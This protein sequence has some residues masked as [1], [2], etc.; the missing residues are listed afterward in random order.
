V[1]LIRYEP[2]RVATVVASVG[3][4]AF[5]VG[6]GWPLDGPS[7]TA[8]AF[9]S[10]HPARIDDYSDLPGT[11][12]AQTRKAGIT[13]TVAV[14]ITVDGHA[15]GAV[16]VATTGPEPLPSGIDAR[17]SNFTGLVATAISNASARSELIASRAR[18]VSAGDEARRRIERNLHD[19]TQQR[20]IALGLDLQRARAETPADSG[21]AH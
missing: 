14:P 3:D 19:G 11:I 16:C 5:P 2:D 7:A 17:L 18:I 20:L 12:A 9:E 15:W 21:P 8:G 13:S 4:D 6:S 10:G 1:W